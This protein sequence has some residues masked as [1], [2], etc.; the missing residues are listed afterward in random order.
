[1][2]PKKNITYERYLFKQA[3]PKDG[4]S[5]VNYVTRLKRLGE[6]CE[7]ADLNT[8]IKDHFIHTCTSSSLQKKLLRE[9]TLTLEILLK[10]ARNEEISLSQANE[11][12]NPND[13]SIEELN[14]VR[15]KFNNR[16]KNEQE[17]NCR[18]CG[19]KFFPGHL[20]QSVK[21]VT[22]VE[23]KIIYRQFVYHRNMAK[24]INDT[25]EIDRT[26]KRANQVQQNASDGSISEEESEKEHSLFSVENNKVLNSVTNYAKIL[27][28]NVP[29]KLMID[30]G[31]T[32]NVID[33]ET[34][35]K[36]KSKYL[37]IVLKISKTKLYPYA[38]QPVKVVGK[39]NALFETKKQM[40]SSVI[41]VIDKQKIWKSI[42]YRHRKT[43]ET[44]NN[45]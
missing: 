45:R 22:N 12:K 21:Y 28:E 4:E 20:R 3:K 29:I 41:Y 26:R 31:C 35:S 6:S 25:V 33:R 13:E 19:E 30:T 2:K 37:N 10:V 36:I 17:N 8:E 34:F 14:R 38:S 16:H 11:M 23:K 5:S 9:D 18:N 42:G 40:C 15:G 7:Y 27:V 24:I 44:S 1:M 43:I 39:F 32:T